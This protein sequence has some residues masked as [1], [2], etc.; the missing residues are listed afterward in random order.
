[1]AYP[2]D[3]G[4]TAFPDVARRN[5][6]QENVEVP[7]LV[8]LMRLPRHG[9][10]LEVGCGQGIAIPV[11]CRTCEPTRMV[12]LDIDDELIG[13]AEERLAETGVDAELITGDVRNMPFE[14]SS[15]DTVIDFGTCYW[16][17]RC[18]DALSEIARVLR[19]GGLFVEETTMMQLLSHPKGALDRVI[20]WNS[21]PRLER[22]RNAIVWSS[23]LR[24]R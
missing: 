12:G 15:F 13:M 22:H 7:I 1:M 5:V 11:I 3:D 23:K 6:F 14:N 17:S 16:I 4:Y 20:P 9:R 21:E 2:L 18:E 8:R 24:R 10:I 19:P